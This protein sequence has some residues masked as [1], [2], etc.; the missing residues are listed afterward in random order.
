MKG[1]H[2]YK[3]KK[4]EINNKYLTI[5][6]NDGEEKKINTMLINK[7]I[8][9]SQKQKSDKLNNNFKE[10]ELESQDNSQRQKLSEI[11]KINNTE[12]INNKYNEKV[13]EDFKD[14][15]EPSKGNSSSFSSDSKDMNLENI[16]EVENSF[17]IFEITITQFLKCFMCK[18]MRIKKKINENAI[19]ILNKKLDIITYIRNM[20]LFDII[21]KTV[22]DN[23]RNDIINFLCRPIVSIKNN[24]KKEFDKFYKNF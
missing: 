20:I 24:Q 5:I 16:S 1:I 3:N 8:F 14:S 17:N 15:K 18:R 7:K 19:K 9:K 23:D 2:I 22:V 21:N 12:I 10:N 13:N 6:K 4:P 11:R